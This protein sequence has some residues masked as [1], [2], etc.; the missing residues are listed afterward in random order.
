MNYVLLCCALLATLSVRAQTDNWA[1]SAISPA[2]TLNA[3]AVIRFDELTYVVHSPSEAVLRVRQVITILNEKADGKA[4]LVVPYDRFSKVTDIE[5]TIFDASGKPIKRLKRAEITDLAYSQDNYA[6]DSRYK[7][8][9]FSRQLAYPYT[10]EFSYEISS[11]N[12]MFYPTWQPQDDDRLSV[13]HSRFSVAVPATMPLRYKEANL[14]RP[15]IRRASTDMTDGLAY[16]WQVDTLPAI[17]QEPLA[18]LLAELVPTVY[19]APGQFAVQDYAGSCA[20]WKDVGA[21]YYALNKGRDALPDAVR[22]Q[23]QQLVANEKT[24]AGKVQ[25]IYEHLQKQARYVSIQ[26][27]LGGW[28]T[29]EASRVAQT[30]YGDCK[31]LTNYTKAMLGAVGIPAYE[32]LVK[33]GESAPDIRTDL[34]GF[35]FNHVFLCVPAEGDTLWLECTS[36]HNAVGYLG[37][38]T[39][40]RHVLLITPDGGKLVKTPS[41]SPDNNRQQRFATVVL[42]P[43]GAATVRVRSLYTGLQQEP[44]A[45]VIHNLTHD[46]QR[47]WL[48]KNTNLPSF[49]LTDFSFAE[50]KAVIPAV[51]EMMTLTTRR[52]ASPSGQRL[53]LPLN[54]LSATSP[55]PV[56]TKPRKTPVILKY[57]YDFEDTDTVRYTLPDGYAPEFAL[58]PLTL[59]SKFGTYQARAEVQGNQLVYTRHLRMHRG[60]YPAEAYTEYADFRKKIAKADRAQ[61]VLIKK[62]IAAGLPK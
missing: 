57:T 35:Q 25:K 11:R 41:Y 8:A 10:V 47:D 44:Y 46:Q 32:A 5:G 6:D 1:V 20:T 12:L 16:V 45:G 62:E 49:E 4:R 39:G 31:A 42:I 30:H 28:Q 34:P 23:V 2:M 27:G 54:L 17:E 33:A 50:T 61:L 24:V 56:L 53:F 55:A 7:V 19:T 51:A 37:N 13:V 36:Q 40:D 21:F 15:L 9:E 59:D 3:D 18:P 22:Q 52:W 14:A 43:D 38:F 26:L 58:A 48:I 60:R 29:I